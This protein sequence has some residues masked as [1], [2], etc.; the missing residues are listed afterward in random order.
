MRPSG[1]HEPYLIR[2]P[3]QRH[4]TDELQVDNSF[5]PEI[6][7]NKG[8]AVLRMLEAYLGPDGFRDGV[9]RYMKARAFSNATTADLWNAL[10]AVSG[11]NVD[12]IAAGWTQQAGFPLVGVTARCGTGG[13][14]TIALSQTR[15]LLRGTDPNV[16]HWQVPLQV[17]SGTAGV[18]Q[19]VLL[20]HDGQSVSAGRCD[21]PLSVDANAIGFYRAKYDATTL[22]TNTSHFVA[23]TRT[24][25]N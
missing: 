21:E 5:D 10:S 15:F 8:E 17:R 25:A 24:K 7:Y 2:C 3:A 23:L 14:R 19:I 22:A 13:R 18:P 16:S 20:S 6:T 4:V 11:K 1:A 9:R 12:Q